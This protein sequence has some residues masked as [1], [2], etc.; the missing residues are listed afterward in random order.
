[1]TPKQTERLDD[2]IRTLQKNKDRWLSIPIETKIEWVTQLLDGAMAVAERQVHSAVQAKGLIPDSPATSEEWLAGPVITLRNLRLLRKSLQD[3][4][5]TGRPVL[6]DHRIS[7]RSNGQVVA[8]VFPDSFLDTILYK[9]FRAEVWMEP[10]IQLDQLRE[11]MGVLYQNPP[12]EGKVALV[13]GAGN[14]AS[15]GPLD[16]IYKLFVE[17]QVCILKLNP[18]NDYLGPYVE[19]AFSILIREGFLEVVYGGGDVGAYLCAHDGIDEIHI[20]GSDKTHDIIVYGP[21]EEGEKRKE[22][23]E[24]IQT[25]RITSELG[26]VSPIIVVPGEWSV[27]DLQFHAENVATQMTNNAGFNCN[28]AKVLI[29]HK[30]W[31]QRESFLEALRHVLRNHPARPA[32][33]PGAE[34]RY[35]DFLEAH[36]QTEALGNTLSAG[37]HVPWSLIPDVDPTQHDAMCFRSESF[38]GITAETALSARDASDFLT[39][40]VDFCNDVLW[41]TLNACILLHP[42]TEHTLGS[43]LDEAIEALRYGS[44]AINQWPALSY[45]LGCT[46]W[47]AHPGHTL[48]DIQSGLGVVH[49]TY[50]FEH[51]Q[52]SV[53]YAPF[54]IFPKPPWFV[55]HKRAHKVAPILA[56]LERDPSLLQ[57][58]KGRSFQHIIAGVLRIPR[59]LSEVL[60][61]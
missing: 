44:I 34:D 6:A 33:Y 40:A 28:A 55:T 12:S 57:R 37:P 31:A 24:P 36:P 39:Q 13:L 2:A 27:D 47:G 45:A 41:G 17:G 58:E 21:G 48:D 8:Q 15:I 10:D 11:T 30:E 20:T 49:N 9:D 1:M 35:A 4:Q 16:V 29:L 7:T 32:Y 46:T 25:K 60:R 14:V 61:G 18:V 19:E 3:I 38:C 23:N 22:R 51:P 59:L 5:G 42:K 54:R 53:I 52:K 50:M 26:N 43:Q 56:S